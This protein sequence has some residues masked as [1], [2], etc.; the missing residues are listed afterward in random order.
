MC[1]IDADS[2]SQ[3]RIPAVYA[4]FAEVGMNATAAKPS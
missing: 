1:K 2:P 4:S 3:S